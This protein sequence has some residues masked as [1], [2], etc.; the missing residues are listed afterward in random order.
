MERKEKKKFSIE[1]LLRKLFKGV[2]DAVA[3]FFLK[4]GLTPN[5]VTLL[6]LVGSIAAA[7]LVALGMPMWGGIVLLL[8]A[9]LDAVDGAMARL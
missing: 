6:G 4:I 1:L 2:L 5:A 9:P 7:V 3:G 8:M